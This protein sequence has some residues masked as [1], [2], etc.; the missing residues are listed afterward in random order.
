MPTVVGDRGELAG[1][2]L[3]PWLPDGPDPDV[4]RHVGGRGS[5]RPA[6]PAGS[7]ATTAP[8]LL[9]WSTSATAPPSSASVD[10]LLDEVDQ[11]L[12]EQAADLD[13]R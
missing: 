11:H 7:S 10:L 2:L 3:V 4:H 6:R 1:A 9:S 13:D 8:A 5:A 12:V